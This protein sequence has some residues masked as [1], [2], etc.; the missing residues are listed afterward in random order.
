MSRLTLLAAV[1][2]VAACGGAP[3]R[4]QAAAQHDTLTQRQRDSAIGASKLPG[5]HGIT[6]A[7]RVADS[8]SAQ[9]ARL[10]SIQ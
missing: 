2:A 3:A 7:Q 4:H 1:L 10:D 5:A 9:S 6:G 8:V